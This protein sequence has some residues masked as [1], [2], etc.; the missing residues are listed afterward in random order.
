MVAEAVP[1]VAR[2]VPSKVTA[3]PL[4]ATLLPLR[5]KRPFAVPPFKV[6]VDDV[7]KVVN[8]PA[9]AEAPPMVTPSIVPESMLALVIA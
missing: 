5:Y 4:V 9:P 7:V 6:T 2:L 1:V 3:L 8:V